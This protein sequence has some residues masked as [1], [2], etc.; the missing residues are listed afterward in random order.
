MSALPFYVSGLRGVIYGFSALLLAFA[1]DAGNAFEKSSEQPN[2]AEDTK[3]ARDFL[4]QIIYEFEDREVVRDL[5]R[6]QAPRPDI[7]KSLMPWFAIRH[8]LRPDIREIA[9]RLM[10]FQAL[11]EEFKNES[12]PLSYPP[13]SAAVKTL[14]GQVIRDRKLMW[15]LFDDIEESFPGGAVPDFPEG[16]LL[17]TVDDRG[18]RPGTPEDFIVEKTSEGLVIRTPS[19]KND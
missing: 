12:I 14:Y 4:D 10:T 19:E 13:K 9:M 11:P 6:L 16:R 5:S 8:D 17:I 15:D 2:F 3:L 18:W 1:A 7:I